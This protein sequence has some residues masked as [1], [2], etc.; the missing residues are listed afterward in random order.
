MSDFL[1]LPFALKMHFT[2][3]LKEVKGTLFSFFLFSLAL[4][5]LNLWDIDSVS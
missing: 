5:Q 3:L 2:K 4:S 1:K